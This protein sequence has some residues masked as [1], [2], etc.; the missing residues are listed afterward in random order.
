MKSQ[1]Y[2]PLTEKASQ[3][4]RELVDVNWE[5]KEHSEAMDDNTISIDTLIR[6]N[7]RYVNVQQELIEEMGEDHYNHFIAMGR[8]MFA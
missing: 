4:F 1:N 6:L 2:P 3:L 8:K 5:I 7:E